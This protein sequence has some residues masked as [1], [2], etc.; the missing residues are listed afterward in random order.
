MSSLEGRQN[1][2]I[3]F[4]LIAPR[5]L[6]ADDDHSGGGMAQGMGV[7]PGV[8]TAEVIVVEEFDPTIDVRGKILVTSHIDPG[9]TLLFV[10][11]AGVVTERGNALSHVSIISRELGMPAV[12]AAMGAT[13]VLRTGQIITINGTT[14]DIDEAA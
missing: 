11:A 3:G 13:E 7:S 14:G 12:V 6:R 8:L 5:A 9:W 10:Q 1:S 4:G 2:L